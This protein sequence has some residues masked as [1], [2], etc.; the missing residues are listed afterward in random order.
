MTTNIELPSLLAS[1]DRRTLAAVVAYLAGPEQENK[2][3]G[4][5]DSSARGLK[6]AIARDSH[7]A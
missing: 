6:T 4:T 7:I 3:R 2:R 1:A 5:G